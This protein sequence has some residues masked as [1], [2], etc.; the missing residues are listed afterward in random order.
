MSAGRYFLREA[1][2]T[3]A[4]IGSFAACCVSDASTSPPAPTA[5]TQTASA[6]GCRGLASAASSVWP[7]PTTVLTTAVFNAAV[8]ASTSA[9]AVPE[10]CEVVGF[11]NKRV[12]SD[13]KPYSIRFHL[14]MP[15]NWNGR[16][17]MEGGGSSNGTLSDALGSLLNFP[18]SNALARSFAVISTDSGHDNSI[19][20]DP[21]AQ[22]GEAFGADHQA[23]LDFGYNSYDQVTQFGKAAVAMYYGK[24]PTR[25]YFMG[26]SEGGREAMMMSQRFPTYYNGIV[27][28]DPGMQLPKLGI[29]G[30]W[31]S[32]TFAAIAPSADANGL[33]AIGRSFSDPDLMLVRNAILGKCDALDGLSDGSVDNFTACQAS[34]D[35]AT[36]VNPDTSQPLLCSGAKTDSCLT[37]GQIGALKRA[38]APPVN[39][40]GLSLY[41]SWPWDAGISG[42]SNG[43]YNEGWRM[44]WLGSY[45]ATQSDAQRYTGASQ[46]RWLAVY[47]TPPRFFAASRGNSA[48]GTRIL[49]FNFDVDAPKIFATAPGYPQSSMQWDQ[50]VSTDLRQFKANGGKLILFHGLSDA[51]FSANDTI[52]WYT[53]LTAL[54]GDSTTDFSRLFLVPGMNHCKGGP[55]TDRF[56]M[57]SPLVNWVE[58]GVPPDS[59]PAAASTPSYFNAA[60]RSRP[61]CPYPK[62]SHYSGSGDVDAAA[63]FTCQ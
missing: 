6:D 51:A 55:A 60:A 38:F 62:M 13:G 12:G 49:Q 47:S 30:A 50:T 2:A 29:D 21:N 39:S 54:D 43:S 63:S 34:F 59:V 20:S 31:T 58:N 36:A 26:C 8:P 41:T 40:S 19:D 10:H 56:D 18:S 4:A 37:A 7:N 35:P 27:A 61:L 17:F 5:S 24:L 44:W 53:A 42:M 46:G 28:G 33:P 9:P 23:R 14:R 3:V 15:T 57:L 48:I 22:G 25:S 1:V 11:M 16:F 52:S 45:S 32:Q